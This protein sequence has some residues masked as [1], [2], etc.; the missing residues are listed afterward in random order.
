[1]KLEGGSGLVEG[2]KEGTISMPI[3][4]TKSKRDRYSCQKNV[5]FEG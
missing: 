1:M 4:K 3:C 5:V 2:T